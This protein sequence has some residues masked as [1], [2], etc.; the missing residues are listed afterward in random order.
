MNLLMLSSG[1][2][3]RLSNKIKRS[4]FI[5]CLALHDKK[6]LDQK[7]CKWCDMNSRLKPRLH[8]QFVCDNFC[9]KYI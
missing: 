5:Y 2:V 3:D 6:I 9:D 4:H 7:I 8:K 1:K